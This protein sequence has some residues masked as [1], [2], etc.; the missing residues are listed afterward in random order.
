MDEGQQGKALENTPSLEDGRQLPLGTDSTL[1]DPA[2]VQLENRYTALALDEKKS[3][4]MA[5]EAK[6]CTT[7]GERIE[8]T[9]TKKK[10]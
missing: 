6:S 9:A 7:R 3:S 1:L 10:K 4:P 5:G 8:A 2:A